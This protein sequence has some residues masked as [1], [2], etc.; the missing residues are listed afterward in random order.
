MPQKSLIR[1]SGGQVE[2]VHFLPLV[3]AALAVGDD[4]GR[5]DPVEIV[6]V[7]LVH[8]HL[9]GALGL[10]R[11]LAEEHEHV[12][13][14]LRSLGELPR[15]AAVPEDLVVEELVHE[16]HLLGPELAAGTDLE[17][18]AKPGHIRMLSQVAVLLLSNGWIGAVP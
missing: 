12:L 1:P 9:E 14:P 17:P 7:D 3:V 8:R 13:L 16:R 10:L 6:G 18:T 4:V 2:D 15:A 11:D 5:D